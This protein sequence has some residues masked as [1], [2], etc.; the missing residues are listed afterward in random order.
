MI[1]STDVTLLQNRGGQVTSAE[2]H[3]PPLRSYPGKVFMLLCQSTGAA[4]VQNRHLRLLAKT[5][6]VSNSLQIGM[7]IQ[8]RILPLMPRGNLFFSVVLILILPLRI[9]LTPNFN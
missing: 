4:T 3:S 9:K 6:T 5:V 7:G 2:E 8:W 1:R